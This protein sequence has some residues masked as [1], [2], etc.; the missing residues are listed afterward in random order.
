MPKHLAV[1]LTLLIGAVGGVVFYTLGFPAAFLTGSAIAITAAVAAGLPMALPGALRDPSFAILGL[2]IGSAVQPDTLSALASFP[3]AVFGLVCAVALATSASYLVLRRIARWDP[4]TALCG[5][6]PGA[7]QTTLIVAVEAGARMDR[8]VVAQALRLLILVTLVPLVFGGGDTP[9]AGMVEVP[10]AALWRVAASIAI[11]LA[12]A[13][14]GGRLGVPS[15][16]MVAPLM[17]A[18]IL[19]ATGLFQ[20]VI[21]AWLADIA[22][23]LLGASVAVRFTAV[24]AGEIWGMLGHGLLSFLA[25]AGSAIAVAGTMA[26][27]LG[28][29]LGA[30]FLAYSPGGLDAMIALTFLL[31]YDVAF[32][33]VLQVTRLIVLSV[34]APLLVGRLA[35]RR[36]LASEDGGMA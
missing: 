24:K 35:R 26:A 3:L 11:A 27:V 32:V 25:A 31:N 4:V 10:G 18:A 14:V 34:V 17:V 36:R 23:V 22:F 8:V 21:P 33:A 13:Y 19:S 29:P 5:S 12:S 1:L 6:I 30:V 20:V 7:L 15:A 28:L 9:D 16:P 2:M